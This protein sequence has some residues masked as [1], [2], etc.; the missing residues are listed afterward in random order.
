[1][2]LPTLYRSLPN[3][4]QAKS[5]VA[6][7]SS[8]SISALADLCE[9]HN[10]D[11]IELRLLASHLTFLE[12]LSDNFPYQELLKHGLTRSVPVPLLPTQPL[13]QYYLNSWCISALCNRSGWFSMNDRTYAWETNHPPSRLICR[14]RINLPSYR[15]RLARTL[16]TDILPSIRKHFLS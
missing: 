12:N 3:P 15:F 1:M 7:A 13:I 9:E 2:N 5:L 6:E 14:L 11:P 4:A 10:L 8:L 16:T